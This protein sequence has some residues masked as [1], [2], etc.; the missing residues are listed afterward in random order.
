MKN[1]LFIAVIIFIFSS[2][3]NGLPVY[4]DEPTVSL[5][6]LKEYNEGVFA[7]IKE[8]IDKDNSA[9]TKE[10]N[11]K[12][13]STKQEKKKKQTWLQGQNS[14]SWRKKRFKKTQEKR[15]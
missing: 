14:N 2:C 3:D 13:I 15:P 4:P 12:N 10:E 8:D 9:I 1:L 5:D 7:E 11:E 6:E